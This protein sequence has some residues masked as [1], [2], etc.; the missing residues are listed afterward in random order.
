VSGSVVYDVWPNQPEYSQEAETVSYVGE[1]HSFVVKQT[2]SVQMER[3]RVKSRLIVIKRE[4]FR[5]LTVQQLSNEFASYRTA[6]PG[7]EDSLACDEGQDRWVY[8]RDGRTIQ[9]FRWRDRGRPLADGCHDWRHP[10]DTN[11]SLIKN[12]WCLFT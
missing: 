10:S 2:V 3:Q 8:R 4:D 1:D 5:C 11:G 6:R 7:D 12:L 9:K